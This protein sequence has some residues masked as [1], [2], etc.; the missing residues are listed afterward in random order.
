MEKT[1]EQRA[2]RLRSGAARR[3]E[4]SPP[5]GA[6]L[7]QRSWRWGGASCR[8]KVGGMAVH[9]AHAQVAMAPGGAPASVTPT[10]NVVAR[11]QAPTAPPWRRRAR[12]RS[13]HWRPPTARLA[14]PCPPYCA[15]CR[16]P[17][18]MTRSVPANRTARSAATDHRRRRGLEGDAQRTALA[19]AATTSADTRM[20]A[21][22][23]PNIGQTFK[24]FP[25][26]SKRFRSLGSDSMFKPK[27][28]SD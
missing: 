26:C 16:H 13:R 11:R 15:E 8:V 21:I 17:L 22:T 18:A 4:L 28:V 7:E 24:V 5:A 23:D 14:Q 9:P 1:R 6:R 25:G 19:T 20:Q 10:G 2:P 27:V 3:Q 12:Q